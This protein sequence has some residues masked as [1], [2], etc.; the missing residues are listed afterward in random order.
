MMT[1][2]D[3]VAGF[4][5]IEPLDRADFLKVKETLTRI[6]LP[7]KDKTLHQICYVLHKRG[8]YFIV[9]HLELY[10]LDGRDV[11]FTPEDRAYR[12]AVIN[13]LVQWE[14]LGV[15]LIS[16]HDSGPEPETRVKVIHFSE[17]PKWKLIPTY[18]IGQK[19]GPS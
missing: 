9:S 4:I 11:D 16:T 7:G 8:R 12:D 17:K 1:R 15:K 13:L 2:D 5:E 19:K 14:G 18:H 6:G 10:R 3:M